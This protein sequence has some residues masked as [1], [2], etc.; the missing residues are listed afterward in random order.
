MILLSLPHLSSPP[1]LHLSYTNLLLILQMYSVSVSS[2]CNNISFGVF[3]CVYVTFFSGW[4]RCENGAGFLFPVF[5]GLCCINPTVD[6]G[7]S[8]SHLFLETWSQSWRLA[9][10][11]PVLHCNVKLTWRCLLPTQASGWGASKWMGE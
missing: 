11:V 6:R 8:S 1:T 2:F 4:V 10:V 7:H 3:V 5:F 9:R